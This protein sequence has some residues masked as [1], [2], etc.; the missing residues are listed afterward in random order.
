MLSIIIPSRTEKF[1]NNTILD[2]LKNAT[3]EIEVLPVLDGYGDTPYE[4]IDDLRVKYLT[5]EAHRNQ[6]Q[7][8]HGVNLAVSVAKGEHIMCCDAHCMFGLGFDEILARDCEE[9]WMVVPRRYKLDAFTWTVQDDQLPVD[10]EY[11]MWRYLMGSKGSHGFP[12]LHD[13]RW[14]ERHLARKDILI[15]DKLTM[16]AS[17]W[18]MHKK[19]FQDMG[20]MK[21]EGYTGW[22]QE[23]EELCLSIWTTG[24]RV[25][26][27]KNTWYA[28]LYK[29]VKHGRMYFMSKDQRDS[30]MK[31]SFN[32]W[33][34][35]H[36]EEFAKVINKFMPIPNWPE[37]WLDYL[38]KT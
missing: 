2:V 7:K 19:Y 12:E 9:N 6:L 29:G 36:R 35:E 33:V 30:S 8:R 1:L 5:L 14:D 32:Y 25:I 16:Q 11:W 27:N 4:K 3:G 37:N 38:P 31:Y 23:A 28:H 21:T 24:G 22:G 26:V 17:C 15:D 10:Y 18:F 13:Y 34:N 20:F